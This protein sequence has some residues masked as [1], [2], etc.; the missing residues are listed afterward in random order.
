MLWLCLRA[1]ILLK[2]STECVDNEYV[3]YFNFYNKVEEIYPYNC[4][5]AKQQIC[6]NLRIRC[7]IIKSNQPYHSLN[8]KIIYT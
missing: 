3:V 7:L 6:L 5:G 1:A 2:N 8:V 4:V